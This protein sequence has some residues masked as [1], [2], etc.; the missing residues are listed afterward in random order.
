M[1]EACFAFYCHWNDN[2]SFLSFVR[3]T[4][5]YA[6]NVDRM[7]H[8]ARLALASTDEERGRE[9]RHLDS[10][11]AERSL[12]A[13]QQ[14]LA[15]ML[16]ARD[17]DNYLTYVAELLA[18]IFSAHP[19]TLRS[20]KESETIE[21]IFQFS[22]MEDLVGAIVEKHVADLSYMGIERLADTLL[23]KHG[24]AVFSSDA[25]RVELS[26]IVETRNLL[27]HNR[28]TI[29]AIFKTRV[30]SASGELGTPIGVNMI[31][32][33]DD[34]DVLARA[35]TDLDVHAAT[36]FRLPVP[37]TLADVRQHVVDRH[38]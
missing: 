35:V 24:I 25:Q 15:E 11:H 8:E 23:Q 34:S 7:G 18:L 5:E 6:D 3:R 38:S 1:T 28:G 20:S 2:V 9:Q 4:A 13:F 32:F 14:P 37:K 22:N 19:E 10:P 31:Q 26:R 36:K 21:F 12:A 27:V 33:L 16:Y 29:N 17:V 30:P